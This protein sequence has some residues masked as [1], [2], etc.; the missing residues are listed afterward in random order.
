[1]F[2]FWKS[3]L[4]KKSLK[5]FLCVHCARKAK[6]IKRVLHTKLILDLNWGQQAAMLV[7]RALEEIRLKQLQ[8]RKKGNLI[9]VKKPS[10]CKSI[11]VSPWHTKNCFWL[12]SSIIKKGASTLSTDRDE[13][14]F[15]LDITRYCHCLSRLK[16]AQTVVKECLFQA[17]AWQQQ[18]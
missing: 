7:T 2:Y 11:C 17:T 9:S 15:W 13:L 18:G 10:N 16:V 8:T 4:Q 14:T 3:H 5:S 6:A 12:Q 1:M